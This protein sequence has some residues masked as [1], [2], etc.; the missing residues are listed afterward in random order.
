MP[1]GLN[2]SRKYLIPQVR[3]FLYL[4][5][6]YATTGCVNKEYSIIQLENKY[7]PTQIEPPPKSDSNVTELFTFQD[8][9]SDPELHSLIEA[10]LAHSPF[11]HGQLSRVDLA[12]AKA[13]LSLSGSQPELQGLV[14]WQA[15]KEK[16]REMNYRTEK[17]PQFTSRA[18]F[19]WEFD[20]WGKWKALREAEMKSV[21][22]ENHLILA[23]QLELI[24]EISRVWHNMKFLNEDIQ[25]IHDQIR[26]HHEI[27]TLH[28]H[29]YHAGLEDNSSIIEMEISLKLLASEYNLLLQNLE[30]AKITTITLLG[31]DDSKI[32]EPPFLSKGKLPPVPSFPH[33]SVLRNRPDILAGENKIRALVSHLN[34][35]SLDLYPSI[36]IDLTGVGMSGD[37][38]KPFAQWKLQGGPILDIPLWSPKRKLKVAEDKAKLRA[39]ELDWKTLILKGIEEIE[40][41]KIRHLYASEELELSQN[42]T[43]Q[44]QDITEIA[45]QKFEAGLTSKI[46]FLK[47]KI[48]WTAQKRTLLQKRYDSWVSALDLG[49]S[50]GIGWQEIP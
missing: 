12:K 31:S 34:A 3:I 17:L 25:L 27:H 2:F 41:S 1:K 5:F 22:T 14:A 44:F 35:S 9:F 33:S 29:R 48:R 36:G 20:L 45:M 23:A 26:Q 6:I 39:A 7:F 46:D 21:S 15:G 18:S 28:L 32:P 19:G 40:N 30:Q 16:S 38:S 43:H 50:L 4:L 49:K 42:I 13:G 24:Y 47:V 11:W 37:L 8:L 10:A